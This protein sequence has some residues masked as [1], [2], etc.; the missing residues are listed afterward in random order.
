[1][2]NKTRCDGFNKILTDYTIWFAYNV[3]TFILPSSIL[4]VFGYLTL[5]NVR[6]LGNDVNQSQKHRQIER[7][8]SLVSCFSF[9]TNHLLLHFL[10]KMLLIQVVFLLIGYIPA[11]TMTVYMTITQTTLK[12]LERKAIESFVDTVSFIIVYINSANGY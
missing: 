3:L 1:M 12:S 8:M 6:R 10:V 7:Q 4:A 5:Q 2:T 11:G 9:Q